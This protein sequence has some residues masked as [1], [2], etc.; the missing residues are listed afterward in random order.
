[1]AINKTKKIAEKVTDGHVFEGGHHST[2]YTES[3]EFLFFFF[4]FSGLYPWHTEVPRLGVESEL[5]LPAYITAIAMQDLSPVCDVRYS[6]QQH[7]ILNPLSKARDQTFVLMDTS[8]ILF[9]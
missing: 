8:Q 4:V 1:V 6:T 5:Q 3:A 7:Q 9:C 2:Q